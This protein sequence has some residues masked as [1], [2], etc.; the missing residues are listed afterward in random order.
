MCLPSLPLLGWGSPVACHRTFNLIST[1]LIS[2]RRERGDA[3]S[4][5]KDTKTHISHQLNRACC[6]HFIL[7]TFDLIHS[8]FCIPA[9]VCFYCCRPR[10]YLS[11]AVIPIQ[12]WVWHSDGRR[13]WR[14]GN[15]P[16]K[17]PKSR[18]SVSRLRG[19]PDPI[20]CNVTLCDVCIAEQR[21]PRGPR[22]GDDAK[23][24]NAKSRHMISSHQI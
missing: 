8:A 16:W 17:E 5:F 11:K 24:I 4:L 6:R 9:V 21:D 23:T 14:V 7:V 2:W 18:R 10:W 13:A 15:F 22:P 3:A 12:F 19:G 20:S 1:H